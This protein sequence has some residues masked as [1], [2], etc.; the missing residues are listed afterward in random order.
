MI[1]LTEFRLI[2]AK[3]EI[4]D[5][6]PPNILS[7]HPKSIKNNKKNPARGRVSKSAAAAFRRPRHLQKPRAYAASSERSTNGRIP[8]CL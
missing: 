8:P 4:V 6:W 1:A 5:S 3:K 7:L 2:A